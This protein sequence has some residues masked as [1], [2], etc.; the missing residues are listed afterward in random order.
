MMTAVMM[1]ADTRP[2]RSGSNVGDSWTI[3]A[4]TKTQ[5]I[6]QA[7]NAPLKLDFTFL[8]NMVQIVELQR[9]KR[10]LKAS[11][12][13]KYRHDSSMLSLSVHHV[14]QDR[15]VKHRMV[16]LSLPELELYALSSSK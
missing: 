9:L 10:L 15:S 1:K 11:T 12:G 6:K 5:E 4:G 7:G 8:L 2:A 14:A 3:V 13:A 16:M